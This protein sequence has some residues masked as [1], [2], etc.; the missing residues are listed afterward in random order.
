MSER[1]FLD[2]DQSGHW[3]LVP[4]AKEQEWNA[5]GEIDE[6]D[7]TSWVTP[8]FAQPVNGAPQLVTFVDPKVG[9][10]D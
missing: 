2:T 9:R 7:P 6:D 5:W 3:Y 4:I 1:Y 8:A 10:D